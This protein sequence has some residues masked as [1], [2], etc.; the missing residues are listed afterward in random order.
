[1]HADSRNTFKGGNALG[2]GAAWTMLY[3]YAAKL[4]TYAT[5]QPKAFRLP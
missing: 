1:M 5:R 2:E 3:T 4:Y